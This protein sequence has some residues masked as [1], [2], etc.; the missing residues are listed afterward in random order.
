ML[1][2]RQNF[3]TLNVAAGETLIQNADLTEVTD[4]S[5]VVVLGSRSRTARSKLSTPVPVDVIQ[6]RELKQFPQ[7]DLT[8]ALT[9]TAPSFQSSRQTISDGTDH[10]DPAGLRGL[11]PD[12]TLVL[13]NGKR[14]HTTALV[15]INGTVGRGQ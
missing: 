9:Y 3:F 11:G 8:Q 10:I 12:Q 15:N 7:T 5:G 6:S 1:V 14:R 2:S 4:L 13:L